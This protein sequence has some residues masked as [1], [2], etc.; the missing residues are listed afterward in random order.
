[1]SGRPTRFENQQH[2]GEAIHRITCIV[3]ALQPMQ[4]LTDEDAVHSPTEIECHYTD[5][6]ANGNDKAQN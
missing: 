3:R 2:H 1:M 4:E 6:R 5:E